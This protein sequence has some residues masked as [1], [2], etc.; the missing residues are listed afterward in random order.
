VNTVMK[1]AFLMT[2]FVRISW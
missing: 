1:N 2:N